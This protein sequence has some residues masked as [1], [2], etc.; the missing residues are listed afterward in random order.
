MNAEDWHSRLLYSSLKHFTPYPTLEACVASGGTTA[1]EVVIFSRHVASRGAGS[2]SDSTTDPSEMKRI[3]LIVALL[4][5]IQGVGQAAPPKSRAE[6]AKMSVKE[7]MQAAEEGDANAQ[8]QLG[9][10]A[11]QA[12]YPDQAVTWYRMAA[13]QGVADAQFLLGALYMGGQGVAEDPV[14][15]A[16]WWREAADQGHANAQALLGSSYAQG[17]GV[18][19]DMVQAA[20]WYRKAAEQGV[21]IAQA[22]LGNMY[23]NGSGVVQDY[24]ESAKWYRKS[25]IQGVGEAQ[26]MVGMMYGAGMG[27]A[28]DPVLAYAWLNLAAAQGE[29]GAEKERDTQRKEL[30]PAQ[31][32]EAQQLSR[33]WKKGQTLQRQKP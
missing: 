25:A 2:H 13:D 17:R 23:L 9:I 28:T 18:P 6:I 11:T 4:F 26:M 15:S 3:L 5:S 21:A 1:R 19:E 12:G 20:R 22:K 10:V 27:V 14:E 30:S 8:T 33:N 16:K 29:D 7:L 24:T 32:A 31:I